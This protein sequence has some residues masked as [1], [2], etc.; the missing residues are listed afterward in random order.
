MDAGSGTL[1][2]LP[3]PPPPHSPVLPLE[4]LAV[5]ESPSHSEHS[6]AKPPTCAAA[7]SPSAVEK[8]R[9]G[10]AAPLY[11]SVKKYG[12]VEFERKLR[13]RSNRPALSPSAFWLLATHV[14]VCF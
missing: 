4:P 3:P 2:P 14:V 5:G 10:R 8:F 6:C 11:F 13:V 1:R 7:N 9:L 12:S